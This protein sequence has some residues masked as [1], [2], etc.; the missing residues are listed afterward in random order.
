MNQIKRN[1]NILS[2]VA[3]DVS[4]IREDDDSKNEV[5]NFRITNFYAKHTFS[6]D[7]ELEL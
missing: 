5:S 4:Q 2:R 1:I 7:L 6:I 3:D